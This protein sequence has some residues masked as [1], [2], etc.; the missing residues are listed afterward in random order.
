MTKKSGVPRRL[1]EDD[2][3]RLAAFRHA[4]R[5]FLAFSAAEADGVGLTPQQHQ[6]MLAIKGWPDA[7]APTIKDLAERL[8]IRHNSAV[9]LVRR[10]EEAGLVQR[11]EAVG[12]RRQIALTLSKRG[13]TALAALSASHLAELR[14]R[15]PHLVAI[16][17]A[18][19]SE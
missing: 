19:I 18:L 14:Q 17:Q 16:L 6:A 10:L 11:T 9:E 7:S 8:M 1:E 3:R 15:G 5:E 12:D 2:Y 13:E 4:L